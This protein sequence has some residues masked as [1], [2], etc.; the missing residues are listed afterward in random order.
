MLLNALL[1]LLGYLIAL[2][3]AA[4]NFD[5]LPSF[6]LWHPYMWEITV[7]L[8]WLFWISHVLYVLM[9]GGSCWGPAPLSM[10]TS[11]IMKLES[12]GAHTPGLH[13][14]P[15]SIAPLINAQMMMADPLP[16]LSHILDSAAPSVSALP[17]LFF[18]T[19]LVRALILTPLC[20]SVHCICQQHLTSTRQLIFVFKRCSDIKSHMLQVVNAALMNPLKKTK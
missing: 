3:L 15:N 5:L 14:S 2:K 19:Q 13:W 12:C 9:W 17:V 18:C 20:P 10:F 6:V 8:S 11:L 7:F 16:F 4:L 1:F